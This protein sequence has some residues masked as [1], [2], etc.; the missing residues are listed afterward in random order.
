M[1]WNYLLTKKSGKIV[2]VKGIDGKN[3]KSLYYEWGK[4]VAVGKSVIK[5]IYQ[6]L[7]VF[8]VSDIGSIDLYC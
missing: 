5:I 6:T 2:R 4:N 8:V 1:K 3:K 7:V